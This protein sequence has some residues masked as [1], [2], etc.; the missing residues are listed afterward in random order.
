MK[1][2]NN[3]SNVVG[4]LQV[5]RIYSFVKEMKLYARAFDR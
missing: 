2:E 1:Y 3:V 5:V 4:S